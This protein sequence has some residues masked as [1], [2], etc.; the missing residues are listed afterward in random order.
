MAAI[1]N[2]IKQVLRILR[3]DGPCTSREIFT[4]MDGA[5]NDLAEVSKYIYRARK[6]GLVHSISGR[7]ALHVILPAGVELLGPERIAG[8]R[9]MP[10]QVAPKGPSS[11]FDLARTL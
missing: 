6:L 2:R 10:T 11:V 5:L 3:A 9:T 7:P 4:R 8:V 1:G